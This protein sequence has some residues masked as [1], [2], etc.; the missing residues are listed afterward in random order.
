MTLLFPN[1]SRSFDKAR[2]AV[3]FFGYDGMFEVPFVV[4]AAALT[5]SG[6]EGATEEACLLAF[7]ATRDSI[8]DVARRAYSR[9]RRTIYFLT[10]ADFN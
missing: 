4:D 3:R 10:P 1:Q 8:H 7:D 5:G 2:H 6:S 9:A